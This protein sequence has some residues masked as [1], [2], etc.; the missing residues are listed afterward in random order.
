MMP[1][2]GYFCPKRGKIHEK[3]FVQ[4]KKKWYPAK[5]A[6]G[7]P[8]NRFALWIPGEV[9]RPIKSKPRRHCGDYAVSGRGK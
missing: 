1:K 6:T 4:I 3:D 5:G 8:I 2:K 7:Q 9:C